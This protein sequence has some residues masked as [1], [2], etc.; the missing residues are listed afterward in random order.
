MSK[1]S[2][3]KEIRIACK[4]L[5]YVERRGK[6]NSKTNSYG[7]W[8]VRSYDSTD[9]SWR[10]YQYRTPSVVAINNMDKD[11]QNRI[12]GNCFDTLE[13]MDKDNST[14]GW[15]EVLPGHY[16]DFRNKYY[17]I[18]TPDIL[19]VEEARDD[20]TIIEEVNQFSNDLDRMIGV[21]AA[22][23]NGAKIEIRN[24]R[25]INKDFKPTDVPLW[26]WSSF[27]YRVKP[28]AKIRELRTPELIKLS[29]TS[30]ICTSNEFISTVIG[31]DTVKACVTIVDA[32]MRI[33]AVDA[34]ELL[35]NFVDSDG[36]PIGVVEE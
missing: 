20:I 35:A 16:V 22:F 6:G 27:E 36:K 7:P 26:N 29:G 12:L 24:L 3:R 4:E 21:M 5:G 13:V 33:C 30:I 25:S 31:V 28:E 18:K 17:R 15:K 23:N 34:K 14:E 8:M 11:Y 1:E 10:D 2:R 32:N 19:S 9:W